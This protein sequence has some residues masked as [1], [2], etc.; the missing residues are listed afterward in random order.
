MTE[1]TQQPELPAS[2]PQ[3]M[4]SPQTNPDSKVAPG[5]NETTDTEQQTH[6]E[7]EEE[8]PPQ[9]ET[10]QSPLFSK[11]FDWRSPEYLATLTP[12]G[13]RAMNW[14]EERD[15]FWQGPPPFE[16]DSLPIFIDYGGCPC[17]WDS[18]AREGADSDWSDTDEEI[19][20]EEDKEATKVLE[21]KN[22]FAAID[23]AQKTSKVNYVMEP[24]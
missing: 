7:E 12:R 11:N 3:P 13:R 4:S 8:I 20:E 9:P 10:T 17:C 1:K 21:L 6:E 19:T 24:W 15:G 14:N 22:K 5:Q 18:E 2:E 16:W 23:A